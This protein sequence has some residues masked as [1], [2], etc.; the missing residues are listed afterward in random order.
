MNDRHDKAPM[1]NMTNVNGRHVLTPITRMTESNCVQRR[2][3]SSRLNG[4]GFEMMG[5][6]R[7]WG[8]TFNPAGTVNKTR[9]TIHPVTPPHPFNRSLSFG[10][11]SGTVVY[12]PCRALQVMFHRLYRESPPL[13]HYGSLASNTLRHISRP[14]CNSRGYSTGVLHKSYNHHRS[15]IFVLA[16]GSW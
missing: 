10:V 6:V 2:R 1:T 15:M 11:V 5:W 12:R 7:L 16:S 9:V 13:H 4:V 14:P 3:S 8:D